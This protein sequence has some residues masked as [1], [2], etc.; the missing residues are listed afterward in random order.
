[1]LNK[2]VADNP[3][4]LCDRLFANKIFTDNPSQLCAIAPCRETR[5][6]EKTGFLRSSLPCD[7]YSQIK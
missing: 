6:F 1:M 3:R 2:I 4:Q 7:R 5:F